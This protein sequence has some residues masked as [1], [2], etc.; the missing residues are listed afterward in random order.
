[1]VL[2]VPCL[3]IGTGLDE[4]ARHGRSPSHAAECSAE[5]CDPRAERAFGSAPRASSHA[6]GSR[7]GQAFR[8]RILQR[9]FVPA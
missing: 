5:P 8:P 7:P 6:A 9:R 4:Q 3:H 2:G 1:M